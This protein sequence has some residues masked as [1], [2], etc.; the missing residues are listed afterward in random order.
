MD[1]FRNCQ[2]LFHF[3]LSLL[4]PLPL[5]VAHHHHIISISS[6]DFAFAVDDEIPSESKVACHCSTSMLSKEISCKIQLQS[7]S[8]LALSDRE[9]CMLDART[10]MMKTTSTSSIMTEK[11]SSCLRY[12]FIICH[13]HI[14]V[15]YIQ[16]K[17]LRLIIIGH[18][19]RFRFDNQGTSTEL[20]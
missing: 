14:G 4:P 18:F 19:W 20:C 3:H 13:L 11:D 5:P 9:K 16:T 15:I 2:Y 1:C 12:F 7:W 8:T 10:L 6:R 17:I